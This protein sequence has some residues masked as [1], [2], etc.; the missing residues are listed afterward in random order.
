MILSKKHDLTLCAFRVYIGAAG[1]LYIKI[2]WQTDMFPHICPAKGEP[3]TLHNRF[4]APRQLVVEY[5]WY[6]LKVDSS[7]L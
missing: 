7:Y 6:K 5:K 3:T 4:T 1:F 2:S